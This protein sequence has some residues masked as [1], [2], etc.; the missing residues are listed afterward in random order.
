MIHQLSD[1]KSTNIGQGTNIWQFS[2]ILEGAKIGAN[3]NINCHTFIENHVV[4]GDNVTIKS[5]VYIWDG[6]TI[7]DDVFIG[8]SV[9]FV[10]NTYPRSKQYPENHVGA[11]VRKAASVGANAT[12][13]GNIE[14]GELAMVGAGSVVTKDVPARAL[15]LG[16]PAKVVGWLNRDGSK[17]NSEE[18]YFI[19]ENNSKWRV[20]ENKLEEI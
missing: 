4:I 10:N 16:V 15:V 17:M 11:V 5:G 20:V 14:I 12:I 6:I 8:P 13:M 1:V 7:E 19:D 18:G 9:T 2:V 3:C